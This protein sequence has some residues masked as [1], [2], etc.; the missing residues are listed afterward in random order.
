MGGQGG[1][2]GGSGGESFKRRRDRHWQCAVQGGENVNVYHGA[3]AP[4]KKRE[5][6][7]ELQCR[8]RFDSSGCYLSPPTF[9][10]S[11]RTSFSLISFKFKPIVP[12]MCYCRDFPRSR[13]FV[14]YCA[15]QVSCW[16]SSATVDCCGHMVTPQDACG[17]CVSVWLNQSKTWVVKNLDH[18]TAGQDLNGL[19]IPLIFCR[20]NF[21]MRTLVPIVKWVSSWLKPHSR[22]LDPNTKLGGKKPLHNFIIIFII[23]AVGHSK[24]VNTIF[25]YNFFAPFSFY[26]VWSCVYAESWKRKAPLI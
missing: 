8:L 25:L 3:S 17:D 22:G 4:P 1:K 10:S 2:E 23:I 14:P 9:T 5:T 7:Q 13:K 6:A 11:N 24:I 21:I 18:R 19:F 16:E 12:V 20:E 26:N 15:V